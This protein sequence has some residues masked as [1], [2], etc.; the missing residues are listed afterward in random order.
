[1]CPTPH[2]LNT[3]FFIDIYLHNKSKFRSFCGQKPVPVLNNICICFSLIGQFGHLNKWLS[4]IFI[5]LLSLFYLRCHK[6]YIFHY[7]IRVGVL[8]MLSS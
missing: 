4:N 5:L 1:M 8:S 6:K 7:G 2:T 3:E